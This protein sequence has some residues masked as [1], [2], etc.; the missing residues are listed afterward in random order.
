MILLHRNSY[1]SPE[2]TVSM[3]EVIL[4]KVRQG[5]SGVVGARFDENKVSWRPF[6]EEVNYAII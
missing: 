5:K 1:Y 4:A 2:D 3:D 6:I